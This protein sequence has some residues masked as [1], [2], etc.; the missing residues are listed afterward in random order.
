MVQEDKRF[1]RKEYVYTL[2]V[3]KFLLGIGLIY[4]TVATT[5]TS[6]VGKDSDNAFLSN[7]K[8]VDD[9]FNQMTKENDIF[10][11]KYNVKFIFNGQEIVGLSLEDVFLAQRAIQTRTIRKDMVLV[12]ENSFTVL[13][14]DKEGNIVEN[15]KIE[16]LVT[17]NTNH[18]EDVQ[19]KFENENTKKFM[20]GS[21]GYWNITGVI[22]I[23]GNKGFFYI[24]TNAKKE[25]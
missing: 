20:I 3:L 23:D 11:S 2:F 19:L 17:K 9:N 10:N 21:I 24:K 5:L 16:M 8:S 6:D 7:Y 22:E 14:Q 15:K 12:G 4:W 25:S 13:V 1:M 18:L